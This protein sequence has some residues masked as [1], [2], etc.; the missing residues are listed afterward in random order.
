MV[1]GSTRLWLW[2]S[3]KEKEGLIANIGRE[4]KS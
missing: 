3:E 2:E 1:L 4:K